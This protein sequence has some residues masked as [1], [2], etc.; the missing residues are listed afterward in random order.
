[1]VII[2]CATLLPESTIEANETNESNSRPFQLFIRFANGDYNNLKTTYEN[3]DV[4]K[5]FQRKFEYGHIIV[6]KLTEGSIIA[7]IEE[8]EVN[9]YYA[10]QDLADA[11]TRICHANKEEF[12][13]LTN[14]TNNIE[15]EI[16]YPIVVDLKLETG[17]ENHA[18]KN[19]NNETKK[20]ICLW[21]G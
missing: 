1:M 10:P 8:N 7:H 9:T 12:K 6:T 5:K 21:E 17:N 3:K 18:Q 4:L 11:A 13:R 20:S 19:K 2:L 16:L 15:F 14:P